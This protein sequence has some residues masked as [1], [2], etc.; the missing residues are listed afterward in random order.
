LLSSTHPNTPAD[1]NISFDA[2]G[3]VVNVNSGFMAVCR[4]GTVN[5]RTFACPRGE[6]ELEGTGLGRETV[7]ALDEPY[8]EGGAT[9]WLRTHAAVVPGE[10]IVL[11]LAIWDTAD[12]AWDSSVLLDNFAWI[13]KEHSSPTPPTSPVTQPVLL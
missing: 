6:A 1:K 2:R 13:L 4:P 5:G 10:T 3:S 12:S 8:V 7:N 9:G 11:R